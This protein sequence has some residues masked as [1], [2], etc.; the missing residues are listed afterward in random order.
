MPEIE[1]EFG[2]EVRRFSMSIGGLRKVQEKCGAGP[3]VV[4]DRIGAGAWLVDDIREP[5][6]QGRIAAGLSPN[7]AAKEVREWI[8][9]RGLKGLMENASLAIRVLSAGIVGPAEEAGEAADA[10]ELQGAASSAAPTDASTSA[11]S[12]DPPALSA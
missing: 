6:F 3:L 8:D 5:I 4:L 2:G 1:A 7:E 9:E 11:P 12:T 10:G